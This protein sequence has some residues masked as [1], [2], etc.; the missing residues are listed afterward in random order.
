MEEVIFDPRLRSKARL[1]EYRGWNI[2]P[3]NA[4]QVICNELGY[5]V[6][7]IDTRQHHVVV[8]MRDHPIVET[9]RIQQKRFLFLFL[10]LFP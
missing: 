4:A 1:Y 2:V 3:H 9:V 6:G 8:D 5:S 10:F 7:G